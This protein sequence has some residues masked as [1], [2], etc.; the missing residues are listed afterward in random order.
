M[1]FAFSG[2]APIGSECRRVLLEEAGEAMARLAAFGEAPDLAIHEVRKHNKR[3]RGTL[4]LARPVLDTS[5]LSQANR[6]VRNAARRFATARDALVLRESCAKLL[7]RYEGPRS[8]TDFDRLDGLLAERHTRS[9][10]EGD[11]AAEAVAASRD[12]GEAAR[13]IEA[14]NWSQV[15]LEIAFSAAVSNYRLGLRHYEQ[16]KISRDPHECHEWRK[17]VKYL[18]FHCHLLAFL[19][20][21]EMADRATAA[22]ELASL[23]GE[24]HDFAVLEETFSGKEDLGISPESRQILVR[25]SEER[26]AE[27]ETEAFE[28]G[29]LVHGD[30]PDALHERF[31]SRFAVPA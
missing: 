1:D 6:L 11:L 25:L 7:E 26:R 21:G 19:D 24:H 5:D 18:S 29:G 2:D 8:G 31:A 3:L 16:A 10:R 15:T 9:L 4:L 14:W 30:R 27:L 13:L 20:P 12:F 28:R 23:L 17:R 22:E